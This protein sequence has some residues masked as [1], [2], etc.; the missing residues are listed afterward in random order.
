[1]RRLLAIGLLALAGCAHS[2]DPVDVG[3]EGLGLTAVNP[4][5]SIPGTTIAIAGD[6]FVGDEW[7]HSRLRLVGQA[8]GRD[9]DVTLDATFVDFEHMAATV[10]S[11]FI[12]GLGGDID[13]VGDAIVEVESMQDGQ[14]YTSAP[15]PVELGF[16]V[17]LTPSATS[18]QTGGLLFVNDPIQVDGSGFLLGDGEGQ[19]VAIVDGCF[20]PDGGGPCAPV[21]PVEVPLV[22]TEPF[23]R[24]TATFAFWPAIAGIQPGTFDGQVTFEN[25]PTEGGVTAS[26]ATAIGYDLITAQIFQINPG[27]ASLGQYVFISGGGFCGGAAGGSTT[28][29]LVGTFTPTGAGG[30]ASVNLE[31]VPEFVEGR[32]VRYVMNEDDALGSAIDLRQ[33][34][35]TFVGTVTPVVAYDG[36]EVSGQA[37]SVTLAVAPVKQ[38]VYLDYRP[39]YVE[40]LRLFGL[41]AAERQ[42]RERIL[43]V[44]RAAYPAIQIEFRDEP[45]TDYALF[46][47]VELHGPDPNGQGLF[48]YDNSP[49][50]DTGNDRLY[51]HLGGVNAETQQD[52]FPGYGGVFLESF[53]GFSEHPA[54]GASLDGADPAFDAL[55]DPVRPD[56]GAIVVGADLAAGLPTVTGAD[57][58]SDGDRPHQIACAIY[59]M[60]SLIGTTL[61]HEIGHSLGLANP[62]GEGFH[63][64]G[65]QPNRLMDGGAD[66]PFLERA[67]IG[68]SGPAVFCDEEYTYLRMILPS[69]DPAD[70]SSRPVCF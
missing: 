44:V 65:D 14:L 70:T 13:F 6:S 62:Y 67:E 61:S 54:I 55:F 12:D 30:G 5:I 20:V 2:D 35:G 42:L 46:E 15:L 22:P 49:G 19:T 50:K 47:Y 39:S 45:V 28:V 66:R 56:K 16:R 31:L 8:G 24:E 60:G 3:L 57:C 9:V 7:G 63:D 59:A 17:A 25:R 10:T 23:S 27:A 32:V 53:M 33:V 4:G 21:G 68:G 52:G 51:D 18:V 40:S 43:D 64:S 11:A 41:R 37:T 29:R 36:D 58:P 34:T 1:V 69:T 26:S 48:G 38:I